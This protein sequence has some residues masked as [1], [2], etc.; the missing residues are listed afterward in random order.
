MWRVTF[1]LSD[2][3]FWRATPV[4]FR[5]VQQ[6]WLRTQRFRDQQDARRDHL[7]HSLLAVVVRLGGGKQK[8]AEYSDFLRYPEKKQVIELDAKGAQQLFRTWAETW[9]AS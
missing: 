7:L 1:G 6:E 8:P 2:E 9:G 5:T 4:E 3:E